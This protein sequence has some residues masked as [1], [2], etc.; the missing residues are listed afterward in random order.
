MST[1]AISRHLVLIDVVVFSAVVAFVLAFSHELAGWVARRRERALSVQSQWHGHGPVALQVFGPPGL[2]LL[3]LLISVPMGMSILGLVVGLVVYKILDGLPSVLVARRRRRFDDQL[4]D[5]LTA[6]ANGLK[7]GLSLPQAVAQVA[8]DMPAPTNEEFAEI[9]R[10]YEM[11]KPI[12][13]A[14]DDAREHIRSRSFELAVTAFRVGKEQGGNLAE[15]FDRIA[16]SIREIW[17]LEEHIRTVSTEGRS[18]ARFMTFM[19]GVFL[20]LLYFMDPD[21]TV[22]LF[23]DPVG[24]AIL[25]VVVV[26]NLI[27]HLWIQKILS[28]DI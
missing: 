3:I 13:Q 15:I 8:Q 18:S 21:S 28:V 20:V 11:G 9:Q 16:H 5:T 12:E 25:S 1:L 6:M 24:L 27:G 17:R 7:A 4:P 2:A 22:L 19:P 23:R 10:S 14:G 26:F